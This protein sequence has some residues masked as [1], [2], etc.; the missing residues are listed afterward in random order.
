[1]AC[2]ASASHATVIAALAVM[3][4]SSTGTLV[5]IPVLSTITQ[6]HGWQP[7]VIIVAFAMALLIPGYFSSC[8]NGR[9]MLAKCRSTPIPPPLKAALGTLGED[10]KSKPFWLLAITF[11]DCGFTT[12]GLVGTHMI[13]LCHDHGLEA[14]AE[15]GLLAIMGLIDL[16]GTTASGWLTDRIDPRKLLFAYYGLRGLSLIYLPF[17]NFTFYGRTGSPPCRRP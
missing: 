6:D 16:D 2:S 10:V 13:A 15:G 14:V 3:G 11:F 9:P 5:F 8:R 12:N 4:L 7:V 17:E 1:M